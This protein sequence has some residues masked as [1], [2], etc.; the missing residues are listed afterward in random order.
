MKKVFEQPV[1]ALTLIQ[2]E[3]PVM[4][5]AWPVSNVNFGFEDE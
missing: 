1:I 5:D 2:T 4:Y 3:E